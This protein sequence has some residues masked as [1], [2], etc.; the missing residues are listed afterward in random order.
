MYSH[1]IVLHLLNTRQLQQSYIQK[2]KYVGGDCTH[3]LSFPLKKET[4]KSTSHVYSGQV[5]MLFVAMAWL[6]FAFWEA[7]DY[8]FK[9][10]FT[11]VSLNI[12]DYYIDIL[13]RFDLL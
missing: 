6:Q 1:L 10:V 9:S 11:T 4:A 3:S 13:C 7:L 8:S 2:C 5:S 12:H